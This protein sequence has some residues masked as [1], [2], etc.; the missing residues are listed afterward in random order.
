MTIKHVLPMAWQRY[1]WQERFGNIVDIEN[2]CY[3]DVI[4]L[5]QPKL[6]TILALDKWTPTER[7]M[8]E[9]LKNK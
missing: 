5:I 4:K 8:L 7:W 1:Y 9:S 3:D 6:D 2:G